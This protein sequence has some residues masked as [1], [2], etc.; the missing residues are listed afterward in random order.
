M[1]TANL[2]VKADEKTRAYLDSFQATQ[3]ATDVRLLIPLHYTP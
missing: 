3:M 2:Q 1:P